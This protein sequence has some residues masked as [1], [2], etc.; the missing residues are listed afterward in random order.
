M[1][2]KSISAFVT[3]VCLGLAGCSEFQPNEFPEVTTDEFLRISDIMYAFE[4]DLNASK[5]F[6]SENKETSAF[7][8]QTVVA[9]V[10]LTVVDQ[11]GANGNVNFV[12]PVVSGIG[13]NATFA[14]TPTNKATR[15]MELKFNYDTRKS[16]DCSPE[17]EKEHGLTRIEGDLG[18]K[19]W[20][21]EIVDTSVRIGDSPSFAHYA[22]SFEV[23]RGVSG[24]FT[25]A[26]VEAGAPVAESQSA[27]FAPNRTRVVTHSIALTVSEVKSGKPVPIAVL[28]REANA[29]LQR[30]DM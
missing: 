13:W 6:L 5:L 23:T 28:E 14:R 4:C 22:T 30:N 26:N 21:E 29:F 8:G 25:F 10:K 19:K 16:Q 7:I 18:I 9:N 11:R 17:H 3:S 1:N 27:T 2:K 12:I 20:I 24:S 15:T